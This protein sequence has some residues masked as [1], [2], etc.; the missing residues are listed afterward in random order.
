MNAIS[1]REECTALGETVQHMALDAAADYV[2]GAARDLGLGVTVFGGEAGQSGVPRWRGLPVLK[3]SVGLA[4]DVRSDVDACRRF[5]ARLEQ[6]FN[7]A[8]AG[9]D[10]NDDVV[11][12]IGMTGRG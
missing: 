11:W 6:A 12:I 7:C 4:Q 1:K 2:E 10:A 8:Q 3:L 9:I 5:S